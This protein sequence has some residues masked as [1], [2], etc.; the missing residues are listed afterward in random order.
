[1]R[2]EIHRAGNGH[3]THCAGTALGS[4]YGVAPGATL[5]GVRV[6]SC[7]GSGSSIGVINGMD[8]VAT[9]QIQVTR[10]S[11]KDDLLATC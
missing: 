7:T 8:W 4:T 2:T 5:H 1:L 3:G 6:L 9:N 10:F 11:L